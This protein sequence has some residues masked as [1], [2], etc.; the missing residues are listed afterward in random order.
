M[1][2]NV[3]LETNKPATATA[4][5]NQKGP[6]M[7]RSK[8]D[9]FSIQ[10]EVEVEITLEDVLENVALDDI[11]DHVGADEV[12][13]CMDSTFLFEYLA[14]L[15]GKGP[16]YFAELAALV[17]GLTPDETEALNVELG[18]ITEQIEATSEQA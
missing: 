6:K 11:I 15:G 13:D 7:R 10:T 8:S 16:A 18:K 9:T 4:T 5:K 2:A 14:K 1:G 17:A 3:T 12:L